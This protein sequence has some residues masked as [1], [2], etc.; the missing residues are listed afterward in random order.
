ML[1]II[2]IAI[3]GMRFFG[4][5]QNEKRLNAI[6]LFRLIKPECKSILCI[7]KGSHFSELLQQ[8]IVDSVFV[9]TYPSVLLSFIKKIPA[10][11]LYIIASYEEGYLLYG[12]VNRHELALLRKQVFDTLSPFPAQEFNTTAGIKVYFYALAGK[13]FFGYYVYNGVLVAG[14]SRRLLEK[15]ALLINSNSNNTASLWLPLEKKRNTQAM[16]TLFFPV[17]TL[18]LSLRV[19][20]SEKKIPQRWIAADLSVDKEQFCCNGNT[21][22]VKMADSLYVQ[23]SENI[24]NSLEQKYPLLRITS[25]LEQDESRIYYSVC[26]SLSVSTTS[27]SNE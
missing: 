27:W 13:R 19:D 4:D 10:S 26:G 22:F 3:A 14:Y 6:N 12:K 15:S 24:K 7:N 25:T 21:P 11:Q 8:P 20:S 17:E 23:L 16:A 18:Q 9:H 1:A 2:A 5:I